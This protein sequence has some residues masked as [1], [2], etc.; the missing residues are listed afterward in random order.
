MK[1]SETEPETRGG[2]GDGPVQRERRVGPARMDIYDNCM[3]ALRNSPQPCKT[4]A[5]RLASR[6]KSAQAKNV[7]TRYSDPE[8]HAARRDPMGDF[9]LIRAAVSSACVERLPSSGRDL[10]PSNAPM[11]RSG[12]ALS[13]DSPHFR[14]A[15]RD[16]WTIKFHEL[17]ENQES[18]NDAA[19]SICRKRMR[20]DAII[21]R[22]HGLW[23]KIII[24]SVCG[25]L[26]DSRRTG[27]GFN[28]FF[29]A[30]AVRPDVRPSRDRTPVSAPRRRG[31][32]PD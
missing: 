6:R 7:R 1:F 4:F 5:R 31:R 2:P 15:C 24:D 21:A 8:R 13:T 22:K 29:W 9:R 16:P 20:A 14:R 17:W 28:F 12:K 32:V 11:H 23:R 10:H 19:P 3:Q 26:R 18:W 25:P 27:R 30:G